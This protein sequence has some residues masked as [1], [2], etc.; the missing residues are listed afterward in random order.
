MTEPVEL[1]DPVE[2][3]ELVEPVNHVNGSTLMRMPLAKFY[4]G[5]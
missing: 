5:C 3:V 4:A 2:P 1:V